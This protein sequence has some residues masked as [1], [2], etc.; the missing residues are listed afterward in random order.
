MTSKRS[1]KSGEK[2]RAELDPNGSS[3]RCKF[4]LPVKKR[5]CGWPV[6]TGHDYCGNHL[7]QATGEGEARVPC[8]ANPK[9]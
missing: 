9:Q 5:Y 3:D 6:K 8:P 1:T 2:L 7:W 4:F